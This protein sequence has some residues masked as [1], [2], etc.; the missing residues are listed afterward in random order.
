MVLVIQPLAFVV[1]AIG[2]VV[3]ALAIGHVIFPIAN[4]VVAICMDE[5]PEPLL[6]ITDKVAVVAG[7][8]GPDLRPLA[9]AQLTCPFA[10]VLNFRLLNEDLT[11]L[12]PGD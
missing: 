3:R 10:D 9:M 6:L 4:V 11:S 2:V 5:A 7:S 8:I 1:C 12:L